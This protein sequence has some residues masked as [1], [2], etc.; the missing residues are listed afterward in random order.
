MESILPRKLTNAQQL[1]DFNPFLLDE[2]EE[3]DYADFE[4]IN[5]VS[6]TWLF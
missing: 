5:D 2:D 4:G 1:R 6:K 3:Y